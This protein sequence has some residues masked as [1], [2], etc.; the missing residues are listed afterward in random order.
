MEW[1]HL[2]LLFFIASL[3][4]LSSGQPTIQPQ[5]SRGPTTGIT[6]ENE[7]R[8]EGN[9]SI[10]PSEPEDNEEDDSNPLIVPFNSNGQ[11]LA[12]AI[13]DVSKGNNNVPPGT[14]GRSD[15]LFIKNF[16]YNYNYAPPNNEDDR[17]EDR[18]P[19][20]RGIGVRRR[21]KAGKKG[22][23]PKEPHTTRATTLYPVDLSEPKGNVLPKSTNRRRRTTRS[24]IYNPT[25]RSIVFGNEGD[26][27]YY[28]EPEYYDEYESE[29]YDE[30]D[31]YE[32]ENSDFD[33]FRTP[34]ER[35]GTSWKEKARKLAEKKLK[36]YLERK[37]RNRYRSADIES[38]GWKEKLSGKRT[39]TRA[40]L[41]I[42]SSDDNT[43]GRSDVYR[44]GKQADYP[45][46]DY[47]N[48]DHDDDDGFRY[49]NYDDDYGDNKRP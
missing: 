34:N 23:K 47:R 10:P 20:P 6:E 38:R 26:D 16:N 14:D 41:P 1:K 48:Y 37:R 4:T 21:G 22:K 29:Y 31:Y 28:S 43:A 15:G 13:Y 12:I 49:N 35:K 45:D 8:N 30:T 19:G 33:G 36:E 24:P 32:D 18:W 17:R 42:G 39:T 9:T 7:D 40:P 46:G 3:T 11:R 27:Y 25:K 5:E 44:Q 2:F